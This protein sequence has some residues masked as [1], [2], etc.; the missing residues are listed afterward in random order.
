MKYNNINNLYQLFSY[1]NDENP[2]K[3]IFFQKIGQE[4]QGFSFK[5][6]N[7]KVSLIQKFLLQRKI[8]KGDR[9]FLLSNSCVDWVAIDLAIQSVGGVTVPAFTTNNNSDNKFIITDCTP[10]LIFIENSELFKKNEDILKDLKKKI[11]FINPFEDNLSLKE[12]YSQ[13]PLKL[14]LPSVSKDDLSCIIYTSGTYNNPKGVMLPHKAVLH[15]CEAAFERLKDLG[16]K[17]EVFLSFLPLSHSYERMAGIYFPISIGA[18]VFFVKKIENIMSDFREVKPT[19]VNGV[20]R[21]YQNLYKKVFSNIKHFNEKFSKK[22]LTSVNSNNQENFLQSLIFKI[23]LNFLKFKIKNIFGGNIKV[24]I[25]GGAALDSF[26]SNFFLKFD[27]HIIQGY[28]QTESGPLISCNSLKNNNPESVGFPVK[29]VKVKINKTHEILVTGPNLMRGY[30]GLDSL[31]KKTLI[32]NWLYTGDLGRF[33]IDG[34]LIITGRKK[35]LIVTSG[36]EN[37]SPQK[38]ENLFSVYSGITNCIV[39]GDSKPYLIAIFFT[40]KKVGYKTVRK[41]VNEVNSKNSSI[42]RIRSFIVSHELLTV[43]NGLITGTYKVRK[44]KLFKKFKKEIDKLYP[45]L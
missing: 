40:E 25:S 8:K 23:I 39:Y 7:L 45:S 4:W 33:D 22:L 15:N 20:P 14:C 30:W 5:N 42:E 35:E 43:D 18:K 6:I 34:R 38:I 17:N 10:K 13:T 44:E 29:D 16:F 19:I 36:G 9:V 32:K 28:G 26:I 12:I 41:I 24:F 1:Q 37:I 11:I 21:F 31:T 27:L 2:E 3:K